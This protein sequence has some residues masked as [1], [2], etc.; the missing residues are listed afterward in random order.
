MLNP[1]CVLLFSSIVC[2][3]YWTECGLNLQ[4]NP[5]YPPLD[6][7]L[8]FGKAK[9]LNHNTCLI[10]IILVPWWHVALQGNEKGWR[11]GSSPEQQATKKVKVKPADFI[12]RGNPSGFTKQLQAVYKVSF[13]IHVCFDSSICCVVM[14]TKNRRVHNSMKS[15]A[16]W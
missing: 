9:T 1:F 2:Q 13:Y 3:V 7:G 14:F 12:L 8:P 5:T 15:E 6:Q 16:H 11:R 4:G 10:K